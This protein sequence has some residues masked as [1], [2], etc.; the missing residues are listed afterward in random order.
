MFGI[1]PGVSGKLV[2]VTTDDNNLYNSTAPEILISIV[3]IKDKVQLDKKLYQFTIIMGFARQFCKGY[4]YLGIVTYRNY[5]LVFYCDPKIGIFDNHIICAIF[6]VIVS[7]TT[8]I[9]LSIKNHH[10]FFF[11]SLIR[12]KLCVKTVSMLCF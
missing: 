4:G 1:L 8:G 7:D 3:L 5:E 11:F 6:F 2:T 12:T 9:Y 10:L